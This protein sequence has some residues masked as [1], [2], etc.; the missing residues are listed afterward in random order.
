M[1]SFGHI[2][3]ITTTAITITI[4]RSVASF[5]ISFS[6]Q[7]HPALFPHLLLEI[8]RQAMIGRASL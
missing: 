2:H 4:S 1:K 6:L 8:C 3:S 7:D 5:R